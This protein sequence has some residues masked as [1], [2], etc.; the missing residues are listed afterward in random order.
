MIAEVLRWALTVVVLLAAAIGLRFITRG[1]AVR[2]VRRV[3]SE[4]EA[5]P[6]SDPSFPTLV[7]LLTGSALVAGNRVE[8]ALDGDGTYERLWLDLGDAPSIQLYYTVWPCS[9]VSTTSSW[10]AHPGASRLLFDAFG[11]GTPYLLGIAA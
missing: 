8:L 9:T 4:G 11:A 6:P 2:R 10:S 1:T 5:G 3:D 7:G